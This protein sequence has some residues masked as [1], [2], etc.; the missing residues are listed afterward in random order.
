MRA[1]LLGALLFALAAAAL[2]SDPV[3]IEQT[4]FL[5]WT[6]GTIDDPIMLRVLNRDGSYVEIYRNSRL[7]RT[8]ARVDLSQK[9]QCV[10]AKKIR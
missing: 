9:E 8:C 2:H 6:G 10:S 7:V 4:S 1:L 3:T 5:E